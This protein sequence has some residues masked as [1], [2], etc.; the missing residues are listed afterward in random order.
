M[1][2]IMI[3]FEYFI[4]KELPFTNLD[5]EDDGMTY[6]SSETAKMFWMYSKGYFAGERG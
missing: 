1:S 6:K 2:D 3:S 4:K 5:K